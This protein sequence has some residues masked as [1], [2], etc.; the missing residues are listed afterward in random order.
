MNRINGNLPTSVRAINALLKDPEIWTRIVAGEAVSEEHGRWIEK[1]RELRKVEEKNMRLMEWRLNEARKME[2][3]A[4]EVARQRYKSGITTLVY[5]SEEMKNDPDVMMAAVRQGC[6]EVDSPEDASRPSSLQFAGEDLKEDKDAVM[7][8]VLRDSTETDSTGDAPRPNSLLFATED[9][10]E[11]KDV[12]MAAVRQGVSLASTP[13]EKRNNYKLVMAAV[14]LDGHELRFAPDALRHNITI[15]HAAVKNKEDSIKY[16]SLDI[17]Q[18]VLRRIYFLGAGIEETVA[19]F[20]R[21]YVEL[22]ERLYHKIPQ[23][24]DG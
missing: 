14:E 22:L 19:L 8:S 17:Q 3:R 9:L 12:V 5:A 2:D 10:K 20:S 4:E 11:D 24:L 15:V 21:E 23:A 13:L 18:N 1:Q 7:T 16:A 6:V